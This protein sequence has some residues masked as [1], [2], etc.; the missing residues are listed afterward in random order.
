MLCKSFV[1]NANE[2]CLAISGYSESVNTTF[3]QC[4]LFFILSQ[5]SIS[6]TL[7]SPIA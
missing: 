5:Y 7:I 6:E 2:K 4:D 3:F 1:S